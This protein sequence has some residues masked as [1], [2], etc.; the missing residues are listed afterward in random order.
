MTRK[1]KFGPGFK[2]RERISIISIS[3]ICN[4][5]SNSTRWDVYIELL[6]RSRPEDYKSKVQIQ[7]PVC[8]GGEW[9]EEEEIFL[10]IHPDFED[11]STMVKREGRATQQ[12]C[13][14]IDES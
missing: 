1:I 3:F 2:F 10:E 12:S 11:C 14:K 6:L 5:E 8:V 13:L 9:I 7:E 4:P